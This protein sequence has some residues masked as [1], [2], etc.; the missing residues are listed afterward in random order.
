MEN[1]KKLVSWFCEKA[2]SIIGRPVKYHLLNKLTVVI[3]SFE[4]QDYLLRAILYWLDSP[5]KLVVVDGS[6]NPLSNEVLDVIVPLKNIIYIHN[7]NGMPTRLQV[8]AQHLTTE[9]AIFMADDEF[10]L[11]QG[12]SEAVEQLDKNLDFVG[13][14]GQ[15]IRFG[16]GGASGIKYGFGYTHD[17]YLIH[18]NSVR[19]RLSA[20]MSKYN[21]ATCMAVLRRDCWIRSWGALGNWS[22]PYAGEIQ[23][24]LTTYICGKFMSVNVLYWLRSFE[25]MPVHDNFKFNRKLGFSEWWTSKRFKV[26]HNDF[27]K[28]LEN[29]LLINEC[30]SS[31]DALEVIDSAIKDYL[32]FERRNLLSTLDGKLSLKFFIGKIL[33]KYLSTNA[34]DRI[35]KL[36]GLSTVY[37]VDADFNFGTLDQ[38]FQ[39]DNYDRYG[40]NPDMKN[41]LLSIEF[42]INE[43]NQNRNA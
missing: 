29:E 21:A 35:K 5:V 19:D 38:F 15:S 8:A 16:L 31:E 33:R 7:I 6:T 36:M 2:P 25:V 32:D 1:N 23:Q 41:E 39:I 4:R 14:I 10:F 11:K 12:I 13:C 28:F 24:A 40:V 9:Y 42:L 17:D 43:F 22:S 3:P 37:T 30:E 34:I 26:E 27:I 18:Q 20:A